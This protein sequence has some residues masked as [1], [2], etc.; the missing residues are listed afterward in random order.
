MT[1]CNCSEKGSKMSIL[2]LE[3]NKYAL[4]LENFEGPLDLLIHLIDKNKNQEDND[5]SNDGDEILVETRENDNEYNNEITNS[6]VYYPT[7]I[8]PSVIIGAPDYV[9]IGEGCIICA[10]TIINTNIFNFF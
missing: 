8:H 6:K 9:T 5:D 1:I 2:T 3:T 4:K 7:L 10:G